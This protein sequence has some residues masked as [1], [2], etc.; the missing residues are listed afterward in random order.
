MWL[1]LNYVWW[2][3]IVD[4]DLKPECHNDSVGWMEMPW[5]I[6]SQYLRHVTKTRLFSS[7]HKCWITVSCKNSYRSS[8]VHAWTRSSWKSGEGRF[9]QSGWVKIYCKLRHSSCSVY[10]KHWFSKKKLWMKWQHECIS[11]LRVVGSFSVLVH[12]SM[13][14]IDFCPFPLVLLWNQ[15]LTG[16]QVHC[17]STLSINLSTCSHILKRR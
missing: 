7:F 15:L 6:V 1:N 9:L 10:F 2:S 4:Q 11:S 17:L 14:M 3:V 5:V 13:I 16:Q 12:S 8:H